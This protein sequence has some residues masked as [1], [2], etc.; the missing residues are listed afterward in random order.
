MICEPCRQ[1]HQAGDC[2]D[3]QAGREHPWRHCVCQHQPYGT[4]VDQQL[5]ADQPSTAT[6]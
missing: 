2:V 5:D 3:V 6:P 1:P 4:T